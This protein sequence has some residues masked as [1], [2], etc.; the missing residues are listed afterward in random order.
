MFN[1]D[2]GTTPNI[3]EVIV[4]ELRS[5]ARTKEFEE[6]TRSYMF[7][8]SYLAMV[9]I[10]P[11][12]CISR[13]FAPET[14]RKCFGKC[15]WCITKQKTVICVLIDVTN[16]FAA[17]ACSHLYLVFVFFEKLFVQTYF[18]RITHIIDTKTM[19]SVVIKRLL[20]TKS[21]N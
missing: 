2:P 18:N 17:I 10:F 15:C 1:F 14:L 9:S 11:Y 16:Q 7:T 20:C 13:V 6:H 3:F 4:G 19:N 21:K 5:D 8:L 12:D